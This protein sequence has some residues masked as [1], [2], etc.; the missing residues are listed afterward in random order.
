MGITIL[1][2]NVPWGPFTRQQVR[3]A[4]AHG[5]VALTDLAHAPGL[6]E[7]LP[8]AAVLDHVDAALELPPLP[9][10]ADVSITPPALA[11]QVPVEAPAP[12]AVARPAAR[13]PALPTSVAAPIPVPPPP[14]P[15]KILR[16]APFVLRA[17]AFVM[18]GVILSVPVITLF[19]VGAISLGVDGWWDKTDHESMHQSWELLHRNFDKVMTLVGLVWSWLYAAGLESSRWQGTIGKQWVGLKVCDYEG[20]RITFLRASGRHFAK[21]LST[22]TCFLGFFMAWFGSRHLAL[23]DRLSGTRVIW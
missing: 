23:H 4:L 20:E 15:Q 16:P 8:L 7:W 21:Y 9:G 17:I 14:R 2:K 12:A 10:A 3:E 19:A 6:K 11:V 22:L 1:K 5:E 18:D 13:P